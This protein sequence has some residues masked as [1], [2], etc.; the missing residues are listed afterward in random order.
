MRNSGFVW[1]IALIMIS[2]DIYVFQAIKLV[3][4]TA[5]AKTKMIIYSSYWTVSG[6]AIIILI[7]LPIINWESWPRSLR[8]YLFATVVGLFFAKLIAVVFFL[9]DDIRRLIQ[10]TV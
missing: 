8:N 10:W 9:V 3:S 7:L 2:L 6:L 4:Q 5:S 1:I